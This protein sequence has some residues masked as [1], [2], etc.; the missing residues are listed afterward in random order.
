M[1]REEINSKMKLKKE[2]RTYQGLLIEIITELQAHK[3][4]L[5]IP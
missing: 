1:I 3:I 2:E 4:I 5:L